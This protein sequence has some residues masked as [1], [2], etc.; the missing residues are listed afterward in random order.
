MQSRLNARKQKLKA[1]NTPEG[2]AARKSSKEWLFRSTAR[3]ML[4]TEKWR[5]AKRN[6]ARAAYSAL[7]KKVKSAIYRASPEYKAQRKRAEEKQK[8]A[9]EKIKSR[10]E[11]EFR[12]AKK[13]VLANANRK[14]RKKVSAEHIR[15]KKAEAQ[16]RRKMRRTST[17]EGKRGYYLK[18]KYGISLDEASS[19]Y[20][21][22]GGVCAICGLR[23]TFFKVENEP[24]ACLD[25]CHAT[26]KVRGFLC[27]GCNTGLGGFR[28]T[29]EFLD[30]AIRYLTAK[31]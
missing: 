13:E 5:I 11:W 10:K 22:Q 29:P 3:G 4:A 26:G 23:L 7:P 17:S 21:T 15:A 19:L 20:K 16:K 27:N 9:P 24:T 14:P 8:L 30:R 25:H 6:E 31:S 1:K 2:F 18:K 28:D 12:I